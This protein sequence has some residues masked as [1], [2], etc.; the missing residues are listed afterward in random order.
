MKS[1]ISTSSKASSLN[2]SIERRHKKDQPSDELDPMGWIDALAGVVL[3]TAKLSLSPSSYEQ[4]GNF[5]SPPELK[6]TFQKVNDET[7]PI[8][9]TK[10]QNEFSAFGFVTRSITNLFREHGWSN[11]LQPII[12]TMHQNNSYLLTFEF[13]RSALMWGILLHVHGQAFAQVLQEVISQQ[14]GQAIEDMISLDKLE[15]SHD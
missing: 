8:L 3:G 9:F 15:Q 4:L 10:S 14:F 2:E 7:L 5:L 13:R 11:A 12:P 6:T 1:K